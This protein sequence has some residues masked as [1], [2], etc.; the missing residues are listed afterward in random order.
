M[1]SAQNRT[2]KTKTEIKA[3]GTNNNNN[4]V[5]ESW[6]SSTYT[7][8]TLEDELCVN[9][10]RMERD[11]IAHQAGVSCRNR[12]NNVGVNESKLFIYRQI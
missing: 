1:C 10:N 8:N 4:A 9:N 7:R 3:N 5:W 2:T 12:N 11:S 6:V